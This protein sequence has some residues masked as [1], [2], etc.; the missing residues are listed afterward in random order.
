M[1]LAGDQI[2]HCVM[3]RT[4]AAA[5]LIMV[6]ATG[7]ARSTVAERPNV[8][9]ICVDDLRTHLGCFG[10]DDILSPHIDQLAKEGRLFT[11]H[12]VSVAA[13]GPS[14][15]SLLTGRY[16]GR[17]W[18]A[19]G[20]ARKLNTEPD[21]PVSLPHLFR[22]NGYRTLCIGKVSHKPGG[23]MDDDRQDVH[24]VPFSWDRAYAPTGPWHTPWSAFFGYKGGH[25]YNNVV[26]PVKKNAP[27]LPYEAADVPDTG[28]PDG[29]NA[30]AAIEQLRELAG[31]DQPFFLA[32]GFYK[33]HLPFCAPKKYWDL[34]DPEKLGLAANPHEPEGVDPALVN[35][36][37][38]ELTHYKWPWGKGNI[39]EEQAK[40]L[41]HGYYACTSYVDAQ[42]GMVLDEYRRSGLE[43]NTIVVLWSD[44]GYHLGEHGMFCKYTN[45][46]ISAGSPLIVKAPDMPQPGAGTRSLV[47]SIDIYPTLAELCGLT[48][49]DSVEGQS[50]A[51][52]IQDPEAPG[53]EYA[54]SVTFPRGHTCRSLRTDRWRFI[55][56][57]KG[58]QTVMVELYDHEADPDENANVAPNH[59]E[60]VK[61]LSSKLEAA[62]PQRIP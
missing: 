37:S 32:V 18:D 50:M 30:Q 7:W 53:R 6:S 26:R 15:C 33:P 8:L 44:H 36:R 43:K 35:H 21:V 62:Y 27:R 12:Y 60:V 41:R 56:W 17:S 1:T 4:L 61:Q 40:K 58:G 59:P 46:E 3:T 25:A 45:Y 10:Y 5:V 48:A 39:P 11:R 16:H 34:Y 57:Q 14:R 22:R 24:Q 19:W 9:L 20:E 28:Y 51:A 54:R 13:C 55:A 29:L 23:V 38:Y 52:L 31:R 47:E 49:P 42:I 2:M